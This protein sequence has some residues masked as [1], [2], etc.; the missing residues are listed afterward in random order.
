MWCGPGFGWMWIVPFLF[1]IVMV[2]MMACFWRHGF[3]PPWCGM[4]EDHEHETPRQILDRRYASG[5]ITKEQYEEMMRT[6]QR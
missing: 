3:R 1:F 4:L 5:E 6:L 2:A